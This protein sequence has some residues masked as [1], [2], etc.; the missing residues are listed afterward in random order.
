MKSEP[1]NVSFTVVIPTYNR[2]ALI[3]R[4]IQSVLGQKFTEFEV[5]V[6]DDGSTDDTETAVK[7]FQDDRLQYIKVDNG[8]RGRARNIGTDLSR[9]EYVTF[10]DS[11]DLFYPDHLS[12]ALEASE[13][14]PEWFWLPYEV[15]DSSSKVLRPHRSI[16]GT[17]R[18]ELINKGN[19]LSC[20][21]V[22]LRKDVAKEHRFQEARALAGSEDMELWLRIAARFPLKIM[23]KVSNALVQH[24]ERSV[25][26]SPGIKELAARK[27]QMIKSLMTDRIARESYSS[28]LSTLHANAYSYIALHAVLNPN[29]PNREAL[30]F[31]GRAFIASPRSVFQKRTL[32]ILRNL[33][34]SRA[35]RHSETPKTD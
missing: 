19:F 12:Q 2:A 26:N 8:E 9:G 13:E 10:L 11:D 31:L 28:E 34:L 15:I 23:P 24:S 35:P 20:H 32:V 18:S 33:I 22:F 17:V 7:K 1:R 14:K 16:K 25:F 6:V 4:T 29:I 21:G 5:I 30:D 27:E 3:P